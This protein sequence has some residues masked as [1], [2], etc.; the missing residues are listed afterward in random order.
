MIRPGVGWVVLA[1]V[2]LPIGGPAHRKTE[3]GNRHYLDGEYED[4]LRNYTEAQ[5]HAPDAAELYYDLGNVLYRQ[6]DFEG[7][8]ELYS[9]A[10]SSASGELVPRAAFNLG[11]ARMARDAFSEAA[12]A[13]RH[14][15]RASPG[16]PDAKR[17]LELALR[18]LQEQQQPSGTGGE[19]SAND[20]A[21]EPRQQE[22]S[23]TR[24]DDQDR[25]GSE[26]GEGES[27]PGEDENPVPAPATGMSREEAERL[28]D[29]LEDTERENL[30]DAAQRAARNA[31][32]DL[33]ED[34]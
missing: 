23:P 26:G 11:N 18:R 7:A 16:D 25:G 1:A 4:A 12:E 28:L 3:E 30:R 6:G 10:L 15:L 33:E 32:R 19:D 22:A 5:V 29:G 24:P 13:Y 27:G 21:D 20:Q 9:R 2:V 31:R 14:A 8:E 34:W 17:N